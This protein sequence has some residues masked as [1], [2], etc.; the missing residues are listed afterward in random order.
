MKKTVLI[1]VLLCLFLQGCASPAE[2]LSYREKD[3]SF[4]VSVTGGGQPYTAR[5]ELFG[6]SPARMTFL[7]PSEAEGMTV[8]SE[9]GITYV[10]CG[11]EIPLKEEQG[12]ALSALLRVM[13]SL[14][15]DV[16]TAYK[17]E[18]D[19]IEVYRCETADGSVFISAET[20]K[21]VGFSAGDVTA[22]VS[23]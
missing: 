22:T 21:P 9:G 19:G 2:L 5:V 11:V 3:V 20:G 10:G 7:S 16:V 15:R 23:G 14:P 1:L 6:G 12:G 4:T 13:S 18:F 17:A 8:R